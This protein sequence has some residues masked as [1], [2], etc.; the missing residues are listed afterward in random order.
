MS[1]DSAKACLKRCFIFVSSKQ[2]VSHCHKATSV[3]FWCLIHFFKVLV[4][5]LINEDTVFCVCVHGS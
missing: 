5:S 1:R 3:K 2:Y 4:L